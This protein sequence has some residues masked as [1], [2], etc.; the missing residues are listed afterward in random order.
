M[1]KSQKIKRWFRIL[2]A[3]LVLLLIAEVGLR[4]Y[5]F[6]TPP[7]Y[8]AHPA[9]EYI[10]APN[11][12]VKRFGNRVVTNAHSMRNYPGDERKKTLILGFGDSIINGGSQTTQDSLAT[13]ILQDTLSKRTGLDLGVLN[14]A[15]NSWGPDNAFAY[16]ETHGDF[17]AEVILLVFNSHD[18][19][20]NRHFREVVG[21]HSSWPSKNPALALTD[22]L[23]NYLFPVVKTWMGY[24][25]Y[26]Y[27]DGFNDSAINTGWGNFI[28][29]TKE[30]D[31]KLIVYL[32]AEL[33]EQNRGAYAPGGQAILEF[34]R[35]H[36]HATVITDLRQ[37]FPHSAYRDNIHLNHLGQRKIAE[38]LTPVLLRVL[39]E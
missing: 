37:D 4:W 12:Q 23:A 29:Y 34:L 19:H 32:H 6:G 26:A 16:L 35:T 36:N 1:K 24:K 9:Y 7:L 17:G 39:G 22:L 27:L 28:R 25:T 3:L 21:V 18:W 11:Q 15:A 8:I 38:L 14:V 5:G 13:K 2:G 20:D 10:Y 30:K 31:I 33:E